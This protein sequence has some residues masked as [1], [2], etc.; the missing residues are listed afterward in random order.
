MTAGEKVMAVLTALSVIA[1]FWALRESKASA[2]L[3]REANRTSQGAND[4]AQESNGISQAANAYAREANMISQRIYEAEN[5]PRISIDANLAFFIDPEDE[6]RAEYVS[7]YVIKVK[8]EGRIAVTINNIGIVNPEDNRFHAL[9]RVDVSAHN[10]FPALPHQ[11][12]AA[13]SLEIPV[14]TEEVE[15]LRQLVGIG[16]DGTMI[17]RAT[18]PIDRHFDSAPLIGR[19][20]DFNLG[21][22]DPAGEV[23]LLIRPQDD[24]G[25]G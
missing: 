3:S 21:R 14:S 10:S 13:Q 23:R 20:F 12:D 16:E 15:E 5:I 2:K 8:N 7:M 24:A 22:L 18:D 6:D 25:E 1:A 19:R 9:W 11:L 4:L 17:V